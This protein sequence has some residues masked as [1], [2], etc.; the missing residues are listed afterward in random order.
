MCER[1]RNQC[2]SCEKQ[3]P[4]DQ[5]LI[6]RKKHVYQQQMNDGE[7]TALPQKIRVLGFAYFFIR[8]KQKSII[9]NEFRELSQIQLRKKI[10]S[11][12]SFLK[13]LET[14]GKLPHSWLRGCN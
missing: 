13:S 2:C 6:C 8:L 1:T 3:K 12:T 14:K 9:C 5:K 7:F 4:K 10:M 11:D